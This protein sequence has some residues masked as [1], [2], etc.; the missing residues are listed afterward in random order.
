MDRK[1]FWLIHA[2][3]DN[4]KIK[5]AY[6]HRN[7]VPSDRMSIENRNT[8]E[9][10]AANVWQRVAD[11]WNDITFAPVTESAPDLFHDYFA[12]SETIPHHKVAAFLPPT[13]DK[14]KERFESMMTVLKRIIPKWE[15]SGQGDDN[16]WSL[17]FQHRSKI[18]V[19][20]RTSSN[21]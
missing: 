1:T 21:K 13:A 7:N 10:K 17:I 4:E 12:V 16:W 11:K 14:A 3:V 15:K 9:A 19:R 6:I 20:R 18:I 5:R 2:I 8:A